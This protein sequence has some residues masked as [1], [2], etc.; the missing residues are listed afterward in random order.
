MD[1]PRSLKT[2]LFEPKGLYYFKSEH[3]SSDEPHYFILV[4][5]DGKLFHMVVCTTKFKKRVAYHNLAK[6]DPATIVRIQPNPNLNKVKEECYVDCNTVFSMYTAETLQ[7][8]LDQGALTFKGH[9]TESEYYQVMNGIIKSNDV[10]R[11]TIAIIQKAFDS[12]NA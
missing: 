12:F 9:I 7:M 6:T 10:S 1:L 8:K 3:L 5:V 4:E 11:S 2:E